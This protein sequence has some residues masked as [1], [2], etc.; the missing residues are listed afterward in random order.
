MQM[1]GRSHQGTGNAF[2]LTEPPI[3][4]A[5]SMS[6]GFGPFTNTVHAQS[7]QNAQ[8]LVS[9]QFQSANSKVSGS[10]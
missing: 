10:A 6:D 5:A 3:L 8:S 2:Y 7:P 4:D 1:D 9:I